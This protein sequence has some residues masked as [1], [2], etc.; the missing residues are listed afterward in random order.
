MKFK[1][2]SYV[3]K[4]RLIE[5]LYYTISELIIGI[6]VLYRNK[7]FF[8]LFANKVIPDVDI[9]RTGMVFRVFGQ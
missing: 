3:Y 6:N 2:Y 1:P 8:D 9:L 5:R 7:A 4:T